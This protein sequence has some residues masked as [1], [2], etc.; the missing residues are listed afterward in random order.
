MAR[1][2]SLQI[3]G[4]KTFGGAERWLQRF[5]LELAALGHPTELVVRK[6]YELDSDRWQQL[7]H[8]PLPMRT[9][10]DPLSRREVSRLIKKVGP[11]VVQTYMGRATR[12]TRL[13][14]G[15]RPVHIARIGG[16]YKLD[17]FR[18]A[19]AWI[20]NTRGIC[21]Y[22]LANRF[23]G[24][25][26]HH[27]YNFFE[28]PPQSGEIARRAD[29]GIP[30]AAWVLMTPGRLVPVKGQ[31][32]LLQ[33]MSLLPRELA[34]QPI[35]LVVLGDGPLCK[36][37]QAQAQALGL[38]DRVIWAGWQA[39][40]APFYRLADSI[41][42]PSL[43][44]E[45]FGNVVLEAWGFGKPLATTA[46]R[47]AREIVRHGADALMSPCEDAAALA[48]SIRQLCED[49]GL[50]QSLV[51]NGRQRLTREFSKPVIMQQYI[52]LYSQLA[53]GS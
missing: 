18:H 49:P 21:D 6:G 11:D 45:T 50:A 34:G 12:L 32:Y 23:P 28:P 8:H 27:I 9:V 35:W 31:K 4:S 22:L 13:P 46:F 24:E 38:A 53:G 43:D 7:Q 47:G 15:R 2:H 1:I 37:L 51:M 19:H 5:T 16:Y 30:E 20:G 52:E 48:A 40:P 25:R 36:T 39:E 14:V 10:W 41:V 29:W 17:G 33:A 44:A 42:F 26:V 3:I